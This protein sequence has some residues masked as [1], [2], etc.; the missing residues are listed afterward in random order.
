MKHLKSYQIFES[1]TDEE[2]YLELSKI[3][4]SEIFDDMDIYYYDTEEDGEWDDQKDFDFW[5]WNYD[6]DGNIRGMNIRI[7]GNR[8]NM[9]RKDRRVLLFET[10][11][12]Y[13]KAIESQLDVKI[14]F[15]LSNDKHY[16]NIHIR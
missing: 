9:K 7:S 4:Q 10:L 5:E 15:Y 3:L 2:N 6:I 16:I 11:E 12:K 1:N 14:T 13:K 8:K